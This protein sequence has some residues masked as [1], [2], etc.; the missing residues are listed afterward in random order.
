MCPRFLFADTNNCAHKG[1]HPNLRTLSTHGRNRT[2][3]RH[4]FHPHSFV[5]EIRSVPG[6]CSRFSRCCYLISVLSSHLFGESWAPGLSRSHLDSAV[7]LSCSDRNSLG[8]RAHR[9][10]A[11]AQWFVH[12]SAH[13]QP[14]YQYRQLSS[15]GN[16]RSFLGIFPSSFRELQSPSPQITVFSKRP[17]NVMRSLHHHRS[18]IP[19][20]FFADSLLWLALPGVPP[21]RSQ[22]QKTTYL[23]T[24]QTSAHTS[25]RSAFLHPSP[26]GVRTLPGALLLS[27][28]RRSARLPGSWS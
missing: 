23:A 4:P 12:L 1:H 13:P 19:V 20:S 28:V 18:Q 3:T 7:E 22:P 8:H 14:M 27:R 9:F 24:L 26:A 21:A 10:L 16:H 25:A 15:H 6:G 17:Q 5:S 2:L 11:I